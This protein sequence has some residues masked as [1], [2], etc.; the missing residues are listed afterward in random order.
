MIDEATKSMRS[1]LFER[2]TSPLYGTF[3]CTWLIWNW[4]IVYLTLFIS[5]TIIKTS[6]I[7]YIIANYSCVWNLIWFPLISTAIFIT[8]VPFISNGSYWL[9]MWFKQWKVRQKNEFENRQCLTVQQSVTLRLEMRNQETQFEQIISEK[10]NEISTLQSQL[11]ELENQI[12]NIE[13][14]ATTSN[15]FNEQDYIKLKEDKEVFKYFDILTSNIKSDKIIPNEEL[16]ELIVEYY[17]VNGIISKSIMSSNKFVLTF[18]GEKMYEMY[19]ND[20]FQDKIEKKV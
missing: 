6:K 16:P 4:K 12:H 14:N 19:F 8:I 17:K 7:D 9:H 3:I 20:T 18:K 2:V 15:S 11:K 1:V 13:S 10:E 5:E